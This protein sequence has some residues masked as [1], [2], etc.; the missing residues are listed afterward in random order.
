MVGLSSFSYLFSEL[1]RHS[2]SRVTAIGPLEAKLDAAGFQVGARMVD[3]ISLREKS[4]KREVKL[5]NVLVLIQTS[6]F[7]T[8]FGKSADALAQ[9]SSDDAEEY[10]I[11]DNE[12]LVNRYISV[13]RDMSDLNCGAFVA[14]I[15]KGVLAGAGFPAEVV[16][17]NTPDD[18]GRYPYCTTYQ[19][20][21]TA[22]DVRA[23]E[24]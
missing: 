6:V 17:H 1:I 19:V 10:H 12:P 9:Y 16:A 21:V 15:V 7:R 14:G 24:K 22:V 4:G 18:D 5:K 23:R 13:P 8:L 3:L 2:Q 20:R 11:V